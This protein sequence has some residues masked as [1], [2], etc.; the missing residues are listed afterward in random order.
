MSRLTFK[1]NQ[2]LIEI[3][4]YTQLLNLARINEEK[5]CDMFYDDKYHIDIYEDE[6]ACVDGW[7]EFRYSKAK[8]FIKS[9]LKYY[10]RCISKRM[11]IEKELRLLLVRLNKLQ[12]KI[13]QL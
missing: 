8:S 10:Q 1:I 6:D 12:S 5:A 4:Q 2:I 3:N 11:K 13:N 9:D 7:D